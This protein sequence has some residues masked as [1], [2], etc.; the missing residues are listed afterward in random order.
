ME[1]PRVDLLNICRGAAPDLF[2]RA[3]QKVNANIKDPNTNSKAKRKI[4]ITFEF[5]P[6][7][8]RSGSEVTCIVEQKLCAADP[9]NGSVY[10]VKDGPTFEAFTQDTSQMD[11]FADTSETIK[12]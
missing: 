1:V 8:D 11:M 3:L 10:I 7:I 4:T 5:K 2:H 12:Q 9:V 6:Y